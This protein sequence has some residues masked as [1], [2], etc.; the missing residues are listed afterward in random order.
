MENIKMVAKNKKAYH[1]YFVLESFEAGIS[2]SGT[3]VKSIR[4]GG[5]SLKEAWCSIDNGEMIIKQMNISPY[6]HGNIFNRDPK[7]SRRLLLHKKEIMRLLGAVKQQGLTLIPLSVY[8]KGSL[9]NVQIGLCKGKQ[10][11]DKRAVAAKKD[12]N[13]A[14]DRALK[15]RNR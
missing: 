12:A 13:R 14:I 5:V 9:I 4:A 11:H 10:L 15:E 6:D 8:F 7:R 3:E 2:L 1:E